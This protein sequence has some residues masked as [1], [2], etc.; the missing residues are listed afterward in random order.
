[1]KI[2]KDGKKTMM[3]FGENEAELLY[4][5]VQNCLASF[6]LMRKSEE[7]DVFW[8]S[9]RERLKAMNKTLG[10]LIGAHKREPGAG[11]KKRSIEKNTPCPYCERILRGEGGLAEHIGKT[12]SKGI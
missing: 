10:Y 4:G 3:L 12:H 1:M 7:K 9:N 6:P 5:L 8:S 2:I 11:T